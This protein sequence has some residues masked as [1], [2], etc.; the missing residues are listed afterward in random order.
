MNDALPMHVGALLP[1]ELRLLLESLPFDMTY[2]DEQRIVRWYSPHRLFKRMPEDIGKD[3]LA[4]HSPATRAEVDRLMSEL[5]SGW[6]DSA[7]FLTSCDAG[8]ASVRYLAL[9]DAEGTYRGTLEIAVLIADV[10]PETPAA[11]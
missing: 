1:S 5:E 9:R 3:V 11:Q 2:V 7:E 10:A 8:P 6:R 4:C